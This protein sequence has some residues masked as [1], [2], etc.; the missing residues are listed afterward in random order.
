M[1]VITAAAGSR[2]VSATWF[3]PRYGIAM[4]IHTGDGSGVQTFEPPTSRRGNDWI[5][6][7]DDAD[8]NFPSPG[9]DSLPY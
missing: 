4:V 1:T 5:L 2:C 9:Q 3:G 6:V 8:K 7:L